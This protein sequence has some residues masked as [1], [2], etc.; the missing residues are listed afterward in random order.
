MYG[1]SQAGWSATSFN[2]DFTSCIFNDP[3]SGLLQASFGFCIAG[4]HQ[5]KSG[6]QCKYIATHAVKFII[7]HFNKLNTLVD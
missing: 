5:A 7:R 6:A 4:N 3:A 2:T 1:S